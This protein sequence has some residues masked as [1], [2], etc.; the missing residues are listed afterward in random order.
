MDIDV[1]FDTACPWC[2]VGML[3]LERALA[4]RPGVQA[5]LRWRP[6]LLNPDMPRQGMDRRVYLERK[7][8]GPERARRTLE[9]AESAGRMV[10]ITFNFAAIRRT[11]NTVDSH[12]LIRFATEP[13]QKKALINGV[14][15]AY[16]L[17]GE[18]IGDRDVL[19]RIGVGEGL[20]GAEL[21][22]RLDSSLETGDVMAE[23]TRAHAQ[24]LNGVPGFIFNG[25]Y[26]I[27]GA[28]EPPIFTR[29]IDLSLETGVASAMTSS[30]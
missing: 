20:D 15:Q 26:A 18:D 10:G 27:A 8:G 5:S 13:A 11:P 17:Q 4:D 24:G 12:R 29:M 3:R 21:R 6:F 19:V 9:A 25:S 2:Y 1:I 16:F 30:A 23:N 14:F 22:Q 7:F 28:Q